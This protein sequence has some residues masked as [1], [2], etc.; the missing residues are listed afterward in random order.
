MALD[1]DARAVVMTTSSVTDHAFTPPRRYRWRN[2]LNTLGWRSWSLILAWTVGLSPR[3]HSKY[4]AD[5]VGL[6]MTSNAPLR[7]RNYLTYNSYCIRSHTGRQQR[8]AVRRHILHHTSVPKFR[9]PTILTTG[10]AWAESA[11]S[12]PRVGQS[13]AGGQRVNTQ[14]RQSNRGTETGDVSRTESCLPARFLSI[15]VCR[16]AGRPIHNSTSSSA[17]RPVHKQGSPGG[18]H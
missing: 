1:A 15:A 2:T 12:P 3:D 13:A 16:A 18:D 5:S 7:C 9:T 4:V 14:L 8:P 11:T 6:V 17:G 10:D